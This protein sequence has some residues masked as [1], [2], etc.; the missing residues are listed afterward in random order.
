[1][2]LMAYSNSWQN[3]RIHDEGQFF[4][5]MIHTV[6][7]ASWWLMAL[8]FPYRLFNYHKLLLFMML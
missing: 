7:G 2:E 6:I 8:K 1:M 4:P 5:C 3:S